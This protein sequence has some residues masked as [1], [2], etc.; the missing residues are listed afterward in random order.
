[1]TWL[2]RLFRRSKLER[3]LDRELQFHIT[4]H[5]EDLMRSGMSREKAVRQ[6]VCEL[7]G[8][9]QV[10]ESA[11]DARGTRWVEDFLKDTR[12]ALRSLGKTPAFTLAAIL[13]LAL[14]IG[15]NTAVWSI[16]D[17]VMVRVLPVDRPE[18]LQ[19]VRRAGLEP[20]TYRMSHPGF[21]R[22]R[23][24]VAQAAPLAA[25]TMATRMYATIDGPPE[26]VLGQLVSGNW[27]ELLGV[28]AIRGRL[29]G[30]QDD[31]VVGGHPVVVLSHSFWSRRFGNDPAIIGKS[32]RLNGTALTVIGIAEPGFF[33]ISVGQSVDAWVPVLMQDQVR[34]KS[35]ASSFD[36]DTEKPWSPQNG[37]AW[38]TLITRTPAGI[39]SQVTARLDRQFRSEV[40]E[41][42][43]KAD[44]ATRAYRLREHIALEPIA[45]GFSPLRDQFGDPLRALMISVA[46]VLLICCGNLAGLLLARSAA[47]TQE[48]AVRVSL[49]A[50][51]FRLVRQVLTESL[52]L[53]LL[54]AAASLLIARVGTS[55]LLRAA[56]SSSRAIPLDT[57]MDARV[58]LFT[59][60]VA[61]ITSLL[62]GLAPALRVARTDLYDSF[63]TAG[64]VLGTGSGRRIPLERAL[65]IAQIA[66][67]MVLVTSAGLFVRTLQ[68]L[69][70]IDPGYDKEHVIAAQLDVRVAGYT[71]EALPALYQRM[72]DQAKAVPGVRSASVSLH[73]IATG[74][75]RTSSFVVPGRP[76]TPGDDQGQENYV[77]ND[78]FST[79]G[80]S[81]LRGRAFA[82]SDSKEA[83]R[84]AVV[85]EAFAKHFF[86]KADVVGARVGYDDNT[87]MEIVGVVKD[88][89]TNGVREEPQRLI[90][91]PVAQGPQEYITSLEVRAD[92]AT[93]TVIPALRKALNE[94]DA[95]LP[96]RDVITMSNLLSRGLASERLVARLV[97]VFGLLALL[98]AVLGL[99]G[100]LA[101][102]VSRRTN[103]LGVRIALGAAPSKVS[104]LVLKE[105]LHLIVPGL[106]LG[107][108]LW[109]PALGVTRK[110]VYGLSPYD[111]LTLAGATVVLLVIG[112]GAALMPAWRASHVDP[113]EAMRAQ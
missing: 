5:A 56:S 97:T 92:R 6:A 102:S 61:V 75:R 64:R 31:Q 38:L 107:L 21:L 100:L 82:V 101:Y 86:G 9:D 76:N 104:W 84:V 15:A 83:P 37:I 12:F 30:P 1:M 74:S 65:V 50:R 34:Y 68:N 113:I 89:R 2:T 18:E 91:Y 77:S 39:N 110:L 78:Y 11:R 27:F 80:I 95:N 111:P 7:G 52:T 23:N 19:A 62:F 67:S 87:Q 98:L 29:I 49:G 103:E 16:I 46:L 88:T 54:G 32:V 14:G 22:M 72:L 79:V 85:S 60:A 93:E 81:L 40:Q 3:D 73:G 44:S 4:A 71:Y 70:S 66:L 8:I 36:S 53:A 43:A 63:R 42:S 41:A 90:Y 94:L 57:H 17:A 105:S 47:R 10:K 33:G 69:M 35:N 109:F 55:A 26:S 48:I 108:A 25:M 20:N 28:G 96:V 24:T 58:L 45:R 112:M 51:P 106:M 13:T 59:G 99:Y